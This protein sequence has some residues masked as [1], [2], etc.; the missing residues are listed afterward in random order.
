MAFTTQDPFPAPGRE[1]GINGRIIEENAL[2]NACKGVG[3][4]ADITLDEWNH[5]VRSLI[6]LIGVGAVLNGS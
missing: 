5:R 2:I 1:I 6:H 3:Q 4:A